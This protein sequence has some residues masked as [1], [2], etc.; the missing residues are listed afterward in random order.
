MSTLIM[1]DAVC[2]SDEVN[3]FIR[4]GVRVDAE[5]GSAA[6]G[7]KFDVEVLERGTEFLLNFQCIIREGD[8]NVGLTNLFLAMLY[9]FKKGDIQLGARTRRGYGRG[10]VE[11][12]AIYD[13]NMKEPQDVIAWLQDKPCSRPKS[14]KLKPRPLQ[15]DQRNYFRIEAD[16]QL[17]TSLL[18]RSTS[19]EP[20]EPD[21]V[22]L[23]SNN[24]AS[25]PRYILGRRIPSTRK[26]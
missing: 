21:M 14:C 16:F 9:G 11:D 6:E 15:S 19:G 12:W 18:I 3:T 7:A 5:S 20:K 4:D 13:L 25:Y 22:H 24:K 17:H 23:H 8:D 26:P 2:V 10:K 1:A